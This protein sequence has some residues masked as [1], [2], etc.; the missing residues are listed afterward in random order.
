[1]KLIYRRNRYDY[2]RGLI[3]KRKS[4]NYAWVVV[5][6][7]I[8]SLLLLTVVT[9]AER[10]IGTDGF[11]ESQRNDFDD[12]SVIS[13]PGF[14]ADVTL[15]DN[16]HF[17]F[18]D[19]LKRDPQ[20]MLVSLPI[21][22]KKSLRDG[23]DWSNAGG[24]ANRN[25]LSEVKGPLTADLLWSGGPTSI[26]S[27][28]PV[29]EDN[30]LFVVRQRGWPGSTNDSMV[31]AKDLFTG[32]TLWNVSIPYHTND[33]TT[34]VAGVKNGQVYASRSGNGASVLD[35]LYALDVE[36]G[37]T[38][39]VSTVLI[40][41][42]PYD[43]VV[44][45]VD[46][47]PVIASFMDIWRFNS[48]DGSLVWH[49]DRVGSVSGSCGGALF[50][51]SLYVADAAP[52]GHKIVR[53]DVE[54]GQRLYESP[55]M[56]G[57]T[58]QNTPFVGPDGTIYLSRTQNNPSVDFF[59]AFTDTGTSFVEKWHKACAWT[60]FSEYATSPDG[61]VYCMLPGPRIGKLDSDNGSTLALSDV[62]D[63]TDM[64]LSPHFAVD[65]FG[66]VF[67]SNGG[68][69][70]GHVSVFTSDLIPLWNI[71]MTNINIGGPSL[72]KNGILVLCGTGTN[73]RTYQ[74]AQPS[75]D[76]NITD[77]FPRISASI[78][79]TGEAVATNLSWSISVTGGL[80]GRINSTSSGLT[81]VLEGLEQVNVSTTKM[82]IG[83]GK[84]TMTVSATCD[85]GVA[86]SKTADGFV[87]LFFIKRNT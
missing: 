74:T 81:G 12:C 75:L 56:S 50:Q 71:T 55:V 63:D 28:L 11:S 15:W 1:M 37:D 44:F 6:V 39:W 61:N 38:L 27:W 41:A 47:D 77:V 30:R 51:N 66:T 83:F 58:L 67:F 72:G 46:G 86:A 16:N 79:N 24:N 2:T 23:S 19:D 32:Q 34:W 65:A 85:E 9:P 36:T 73:I 13:P 69:A 14:S 7:M 8:V 45:A 21:Q 57:F 68:F 59:Y 33:W 53:Y 31:F 62:L 18:S 22:P 78:I 3:M 17:V 80:L 70:D 48:E 25:G 76:I 49:A 26:I 42:G 54:T 10:S 60:T 20:E 43:G 52:G 64:Y 84:V 4:R 82:I 29:T 40:D 5:D 87:F 35:N